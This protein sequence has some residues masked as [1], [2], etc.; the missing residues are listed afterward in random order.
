MP[1]MAAT[2][3]MPTTVLASSIRP[4]SQRVTHQ[5]LQNKSSKYDGEL[6]LSEKQKFTEKCDILIDDTGV[7]GPEGH[8]TNVVKWSSELDKYDVGGAVAGAVA[9]AGVGAA[10]G[11]G[12]CLIVGP[13][14]LFTAPAIMGGGLG[15]G[16]EW[17]GKSGAKMFTVVGDGKEGRIVQEFKVKSSGVRTTQKLLL[18]TTQLVDGE[19]RK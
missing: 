13:L 11:L 4:G 17:G 2:M 7:T 9:G 8:I 16:A 5:S 12:S 1:L 18:N 10:A 15:A 6:C 19:L 3:L 14:C